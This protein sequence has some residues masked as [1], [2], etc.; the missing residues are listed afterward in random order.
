MIVS[1]LIHFDTN[2][3]FLVESVIDNQ[4][5][6]RLQSLF[7]KDQPGWS[8]SDFDTTPGRIQNISQIPIVIETEVYARD[9]LA[10][11]VS[12]V[13]N[14]SVKFIGASFWWDFEGYRLKEH[15]DLPGINYALQMYLDAPGSNVSTLGTGF[16][17]DQSELVTKIP[18]KHN[19]GYLLE[20][21][22][23]VLHGMDMEV[24]QGHQ[25]KSIYLRFADNL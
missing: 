22:W 5:A 19:T 15:Y 16:Y 8:N 12:T 21:P 14:K 7:N 2:R 13:L 1:S 11:M 6:D 23:A 9:V 4:L 17:N 25:R 18:Y 3:L 20:N 10:P 24:P